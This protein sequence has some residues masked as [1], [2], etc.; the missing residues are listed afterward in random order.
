MLRFVPTTTPASLSL[1][2]AVSQKTIR[3]MLRRTYSKLPDDVSRWKLSDE[4][5]ASV[6]SHFL[7]RN[8]DGLE[9]EWPLEIGDVVRRRALHATFGGQQ[10]GG[11]VTPKSIPDIIV[12]TDTASGAKHGY[13]VFEGLQEDGS[14]AYT[15]E[16]QHGPQELTRGNRAL[17]ES[18]QKSRPIRLFTKQ[19]VYITYVGEFATAERAYRFEVIPDSDGELRRGIIFSLV[20]VD[21]SVESLRS[22]PPASAS[23][24]DW[25]APNVSDY[26]LPGV[27][28][29][30]ARSASRIEFEL[31]ADFGAWLGANGRKPNRLRL[32]S[33]GVTIEPDMYVAE[34][35]WVIEAKMSPARQY[36]RT[37]IGQV[38]DYVNVARATGLPATPMILLPSAPV[39][40][41][42]G[43]LSQLEIAVAVR[44]GSSF[45]VINPTP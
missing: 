18:A 5:A 41:L 11:I 13:D 9:K 25:V 30:E 36:V 4:Q 17:A 21:A 31:Q 27:S 26:A 10:Q 8:P 34:T 14:F 12:I 43:L 32:P 39:D 20:P 24:S 2:L 7:S 42:M 33:A 45:V 29:P 35:G 22:E 38:L 28:S 6:R 23:M 19:G 44:D 3:A 15:G 37:A 1:E 40:D 16:G